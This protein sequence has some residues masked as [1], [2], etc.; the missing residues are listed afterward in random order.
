MI[1]KIKFYYEEG[2]NSSNRVKWCLDYKNIEYEL[3]NTSN[4]DIEEYKKINPFI[5]IPGMLFNNTPLSES[6]AMI[7]LIEESFPEPSLFPD[8]KIA[9]AKVRE[10]CEIINATIHPVQNSKVPLFFIPSLNKNEIQ[11]YRVS[12]IKQNLEKLLPLLFLESKFAVGK[13]FTIADIFLICIYYKGLEMGLNKDYFKSLNNH[14]ENCLSIPLI[15][16][17]CPINKLKIE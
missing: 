16:S 6:V 11:T 4:I 10:V 17:S 7:E 14:L 1:D 9:K 12:W 8:S 5:R 3:I 15:K 13:C 2:S